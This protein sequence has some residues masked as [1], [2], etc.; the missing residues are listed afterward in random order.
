MCVCGGGVSLRVFHAHCG[1]FV[2]PGVWG[3]CFFVIVGYWGFPT[4]LLERRKR[5]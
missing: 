1:N 5:R 4:S 2:Q 3:F